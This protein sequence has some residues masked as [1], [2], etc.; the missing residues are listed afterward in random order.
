MRV[1]AIVKPMIILSQNYKLEELL[2]DNEV[3]MVHADEFNDAQCDRILTQVEAEVLALTEEKKLKKRIFYVLVESMQNITRHS[4]SSKAMMVE[5]LP[6]LALGR[7]KDN[8]YILTA[9]PIHNDNI[10]KLKE[11]IDMINRTGMGELRQLYRDTLNDGGFNDAGGASLG[12]IDIVRKAGGQLQYGFDKIDTDHSY[13]IL[14]INIE[15][16]A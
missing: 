2:R 1:Q 8:P 12:L 10:P 13:F 15:G 16:N 3:L 6:M 7:Q 11:H 5:N 4:A 9:N 14:K